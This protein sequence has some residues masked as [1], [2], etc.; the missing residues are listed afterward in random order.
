MLINLFINRIQTF[1]DTV[2]L[3]TDISHMR[4]PYKVG[5][6]P[7]VAT[8]QDKAWQ[9]EDK[10][11]KKATFFYALNTT[12]QTRISTIDKHDLIE[13]PWHE[14]LKAYSLNV[15]TKRLS[16]TNRRK[17]V[18]IARELVIKSELFTTF[19]KDSV[20]KYWKKV[21][22]GR[23]LGLLQSFIRWLKIHELIPLTVEVPRDVREARDGAE[24]LQVNQ[25]KLPDEKAVM[26][27][28]AIQHQVIPWDKS[29]WNNIYP[30]DNQRDAFVCLM[31]ALSLSSPNRVNAEQTV[32][33]QQSLKTKTEMIDGRIETAH[34]LDWSGSK[35]FA[36]N[37]NHIAANMAAVISLALDYM[38]LITAPNRVLA[39]FYKNP[40]KPLNDV[41][42][43]FKVE[44]TKWYYVNHDPEQPINLFTLG[45]LLGFYERTPI[46]VV[47]V[48]EGVIGAQKVGKFYVKPIAKLQLG[49]KVIVSNTQLAR[50]LGKQTGSTT[51]SRDLDIQGIVT[52]RAIQNRWIAH[53]KKQ[54]PSFPMVRNESNKGSCDIEHRLFALNSWQ[55][56][57]KGMSGGN[58]YK[59]SNSP[60]S[61]IS[62]VTM[63]K[64]YIN[65]LTSSG[66][67][68]KTIFRRHGFSQEFR[69]SPHQ[70]RHYLTDLADKGGLPVAVNN[71]WGAKN[72][73]QIIHYVHSTDD[74]KASVIADI[75]Y[76][77]NSKSQEEIKETIRLVSR[78]EYE[79]VTGEHGTASVSSSGV[80]TQNLIVTPCQYLNDFLT[81]CVGCPKSCHISHDQ[82]AI[83]IL[84]QDLSVQ[85]KRLLSVQSRPQFR[86]SQAMQ[87]W[88]KL[89]LINTERLRQLI[90]LM[91]DSKI[92]PGSL[93]RMI[94]DSAEF[95]ISNLKAKQVEVRK[96][97]L[98]DVKV[99]LKVLL[100]DKQEKDEVVNRLLDLF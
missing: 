59:G 84:Q 99:A 8:W 30:L 35:G 51:L 21:G 6:V 80:C 55:L 73:S 36:D 20:T 7:P 9:Y 71:M 67:N 1:V 47:R 16:A 10:N 81:Q 25:L 32:L 90:S 100:E 75:L 46:K 91:T 43:G 39:R 24:E 70:M 31:F 79:S 85:E 18:S 86:S 64:C 68:N 74:E 33:N 19:E 3:E 23:N 92:P 94:V 88:F 66:N 41:L 87:E 97:A 45:F 76:K 52:V 78:Q 62:P 60:F 12:G 95:R 11:G 83:S 56:G 69:I 50:L 44:E 4:G 15:A 48:E 77:E 82:Q 27:M 29:E 65:D 93:I 13:A 54:Y 38:E 14:L 17:K 2:M 57:L 98:P 37:K 40:F 53:L 63:G 61:I 28:G 49:D 89:H 42:R 22:F 58:D 26:A 72:P 96:L 5:E 34:Y